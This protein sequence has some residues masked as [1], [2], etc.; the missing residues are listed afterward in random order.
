MQTAHFQISF[1]NELKSSLIKDV[2]DKTF[3]FVLTQLKRV[4][5]IHV[6]LNDNLISFDSIKLCNN[7]INYS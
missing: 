2:N 7:R 4:I 1:L 5:N 6:H 3:R